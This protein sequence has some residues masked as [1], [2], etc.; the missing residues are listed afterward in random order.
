MYYKLLGR[1]SEDLTDLLNDIKIESLRLWDETPSIK[2]MP[3]ILSRARVI[4]FQDPALVK[5]L[6]ESIF[7]EIFQDTDIRVIN[8]QVFVAPP[9]S[10]NI[11][12]KDGV[13]K[14]SAFN[15]IIQGTKNDWTRWYSDELIESFGGKLHVLSLHASNLAKRYS[16]NISNLPNFPE[17]PCTEELTGLMLP[18]TVYLIN[19]DIYHAFSNNSDEFRIVLQTNFVKDPPDRN[20]SVEELDAKIQ[21]TGLLNVNPL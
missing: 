1:I 8:H 16:R 17:L 12:H 21:Q 18:G 4:Q 6:R 14:K 7:P 19:T 11:I 5:R 9:H 2:V 3:N 15:I 13:A 10:G 20:P